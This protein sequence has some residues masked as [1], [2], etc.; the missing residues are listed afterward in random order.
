V[1]VWGDCYASVLVKLA[2]ILP[3]C[4]PFGLQAGRL[5]NIVAYI[6]V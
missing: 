3:G 1:D 4:V 5:D 6:E 2:F